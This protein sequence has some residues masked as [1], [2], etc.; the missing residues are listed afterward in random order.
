MA[1]MDTEVPALLLRLDGNPF[2]H[3]TLGAVRTLGRAGVETHVL[4]DEPAGPVLR[5]RHLYR[6]HRRPAGAT[7]DHPR[8]LDELR[9]IAA[10]IGRRAVLLAMD[11]RGAIAVARLATELT[12]HY[13][14]PSIPA[15]LPEQLTDKSELALLCARLNVPHPATRLPGTAAEAAAA[16]EEMGGRAVAKWVRPWLLPPDSGLRGTSLVPDVSGLF[17]RPSLVHSR[18][19]SPAW[20]TEVKERQ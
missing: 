13:L 11:D 12:D 1:S 19:T 7:V 16:L 9:R 2:H 14:L 17:G 3:G 15:E 6:A 8:L 10:L 20:P 4:L 18:T 5:S